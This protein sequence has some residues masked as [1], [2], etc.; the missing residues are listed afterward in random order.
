MWRDLWR[1]C[2]EPDRSGL[3]GGR[4]RAGVAAA[5]L[6]ADSFTQVVNAGAYSESLESLCSCA[7]ADDN[8]CV[9]TSSSLPGARRGLVSMVSWHV[10]SLVMGLVLVFVPG[11]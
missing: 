2:D 1:V 11:R 8:E 9:D 6:Q 3:G 4:L 7:V 10:I 5:G